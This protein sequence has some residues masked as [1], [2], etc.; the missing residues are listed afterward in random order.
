MIPDIESICRPKENW[1]EVTK[2]VFPVASIAE[3]SKSNP[4]S[5]SSKP[6]HAVAGMGLHQSM[7]GMLLERRKNQISARNVPDVV[8]EV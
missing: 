2:K 3:F 7:R 8:I 1:V 5:K 6:E 4:L